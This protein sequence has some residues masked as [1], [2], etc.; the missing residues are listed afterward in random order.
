MLSISYT[1]VF[2]RNYKY[3]TDILIMI[4]YTYACL[5]MYVHDCAQ[6]MYV[7]LLL[8][9]YIF[10]CIIKTGITVHSPLTAQVCN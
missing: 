1:F 6:S 2:Q 3:T 4:I 10:T 9:T 8:L 7:T 5:H